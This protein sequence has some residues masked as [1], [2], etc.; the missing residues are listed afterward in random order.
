MKKILVLLT[1]LPSL[2]FSQSIIERTT[3][4]TDGITRVFT[5]KESLVLSLGYATIS[6]QG[7]LFSD[8]EKKLNASR[9]DFSL[10]AGRDLVL[11]R[12]ISSLT[13]TLENDETVL[14]YYL[15]ENE[16]VNQGDAY[17][18]LTVPDGP[19]FNLLS[20]SKV[21]GIALNIGGK[22]EYTVKPKQSD[23]IA[24]ISKLIIQEIP[25]E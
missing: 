5:S 12:N 1:L 18:F 14:L 23:L 6:V 4:K 21:K 7:I 17:I 2:C 22:D 13:L 10:T 24:N 3:D 19:Q 8:K 11:K 15:G 25:V 20:T 9:L 16:K